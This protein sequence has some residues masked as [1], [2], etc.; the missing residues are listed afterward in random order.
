MYIGLHVKYHLLL[1]DFKGTG[2]FSTDFFF[3]KILKYI[4]SSKC[5]RWEAGCSLPVDGKS[6]RDVA[7]THFSQFCKKPLKK[8]ISF[9]ESTFS[10]L[11]YRG[12]DKSLARPGTK[13][14]TF[15]TFYGTWR[16]ITQFTKFN[17]CT[18]PSQINP[19]SLPITLL[20]GAAFFLPGRAKDLSA[21]R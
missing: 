21:R 16:F 5:V 11:L 15:P 6:R 19:F 3:S 14:A 1:S 12:A 9:S 2:I 20:T 10:V 13:Q 17:T 4:I 8:S 7:N 18:Y